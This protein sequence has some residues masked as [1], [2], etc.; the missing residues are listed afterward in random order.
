MIHY[1]LLKYIMG[2]VMCKRIEDDKC[3]KENTSS[4]EKDVNLNTLK[5]VFKRRAEIFKDIVDDYPIY[6]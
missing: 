5:Y 1:M 6:G 2:C 4:N 3:L